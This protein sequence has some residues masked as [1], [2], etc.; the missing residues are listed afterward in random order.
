[1]FAAGWQAATFGASLLFDPRIAWGVS[2]ILFG[3]LVMTIGALAAQSA[4]RAN[5]AAR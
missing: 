3:L 4:H 5:E 1:M 2:E